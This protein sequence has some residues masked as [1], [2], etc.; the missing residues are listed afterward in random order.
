MRLNLGCGKDIRKDY[1]N[2]D[3]TAHTGVT[4]Q[5]IRKLD[6]E[7]ESVDE[8]LLNQVLEHF[9]NKD[10]RPSL[11]EWNRVLKK[12]GKIVITV[13]NAIGTVK[14]FLNGTLNTSGFGRHYKHWSSEEVVFQM[15]Y[16]RADI[17][18]DNEPEYQQHRTGFCYN[19]L[20]RF[21]E[22]CGF[23][24]TKVNDETDTNQDLEVEAIKL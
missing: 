8:I 1:I 17:F 12:G 14:S 15:L 20:K 4:V 22:E 10:L 19:R 16:G 5:D 18:G 23:K 7:N 24:I 6:Y 13:P 11:K 21:L 2:I 9:N 3:A